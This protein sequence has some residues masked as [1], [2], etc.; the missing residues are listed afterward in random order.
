MEQKPFNHPRFG[1][2]YLDGAYGK[3]REG[4]AA[5]L[6]TVGRSVVGRDAENVIIR[7]AA[8]VKANGGKPIPLVAR[9]WDC[10]AAAHAY[11]AEPQLFSAVR[12]SEPPLS[13]TEMVKDPV[14]GRESYAVAV[15]GALEEY[16]WTDLVEVK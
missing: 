9:G 7:A 5:I 13:W 1:W 8:Q 14:L 16:D 2:W 3:N 15:W 12:F 6:A 11:A 10:I 4:E